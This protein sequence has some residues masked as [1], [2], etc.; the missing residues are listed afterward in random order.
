ME[1]RQL[2]LQTVTICGGWHLVSVEQRPETD[3]LVAYLVSPHD[4]P[5]PVAAIRE[6][7]AM[8]IIMDAVGDLKIQHPRRRREGAVKRIL[9]TLANFLRLVPDRSFTIRVR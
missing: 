6:G 5:N 2:L 3:V 9:R 8:Q 1:Q 4:E 7:R